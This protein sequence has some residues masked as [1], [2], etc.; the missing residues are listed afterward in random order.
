MII[1]FFTSQIAYFC[2]HPWF[3]KRKEMRSF[4][5]VCLFLFPI[6]LSASPIS[7]N[8]NSKQLP[9]SV[10]A[11]LIAHVN[12]DSITSYITRLQNFGTRYALAS[13]RKEVA[14]WIR[15]KFKQFGYNNSSLD[16]FLLQHSSGHYWQYNVVANLAGWADSGFYTIIGGHHDCITSIPYDSAP[17]AD[18]NASAV[19]ATLE[20]ARLFK[21]HQL[22]P[23][24][25]VRFATYAAE[26][27]GLHG[28]RYAAAKDIENQV[29]VRHMIN[30]DMIAH[31]RPQFE[32]QVVFQAYD[33]SE[34]LTNL[35]KQTCSKFTSLEYTVVNDN[36][37]NSDSQSYY[38]KGIQT[39]FLQEFD[40]DPNYHTV[41]DVVANH[42]MPYCASVTMLAFA[43]LLQSQKKPSTPVGFVAS[44]LGNGSGLWLQWKKTTDN[45]VLNY[46]IQVIHPELG[47]VQEH[48]TEDTNFYLTGLHEGMKY[49]LSLIS[50]DDQNTNS[51]AAKITKTPALVNL[52]RGILLVDDSNGGL[53]SP[54]DAE[55]DGYFHSLLQ[56]FSF[57]NY[58]A[59]ATGKINLFVLGKYSSV[60][61]HVN[62][63]NFNSQLRLNI[64][65][66]KEYIDF[67]GKIF[68]TLFHPSTALFGNANFEFPFF[69]NENSIPY[70]LFGL[71]EI[72]H[73]ENA[74]FKEA[75]AAENGFPNLTI[76]STKI[77]ASD[78]HIAQTQVIL[79]VQNATVL[80]LYKSGYPDQSP[81]TALNGLPVAYA[82]P[83][84]NP[85]VVLASFPLYYMQ[86][87]QAAMLCRQIM[88]NVFGEPIAIPI[89]KN[90]PRL[91]A[92][93]KPNPSGGKT[94]LE[95]QTA[96]AF[97]FTVE[98]NNSIGK[99][100]WKNKYRTNGNNMQV[101]LPLDNLK[102]GI[103]FLILHSETERL[104]LKYIRN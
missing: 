22:T 42:N 24:Y 32:D 79:S 76:D 62:N 7:K 9:D 68:F 65:E 40:F 4:A 43:L 102:P 19:A 61:W 30:M 50:I 11:Q 73:T 33:N 96:H 99:T 35:A 88:E 44:N 101:T 46:R 104:V 26:E 34:E 94:V 60:L 57:E 77:S 98:L 17:G 16:S 59:N 21:L 36:S 18:D 2:W 14:I 12:T 81:E 69:L 67:G 86:Q 80:Y 82:Y 74:R 103:Y 97:S 39:I 23:K 54:T 55:T 8:R 5:V 56:N 87:D 63:M 29:K 53:G 6:G 58:D 48:F 66:V 89:E 10:I 93:L 71:S 85:K 27:L 28:S 1:F 49:T 72:N 83:A 78:G 84:Q 37:S 91:T 51:E 13:N 95:I 45:T 92:L 3:K 25:S 20:I 52:S 64:D 70:Q 75:I 100:I 47:Q 90:Q 41:K 31:A 38:A 15:D